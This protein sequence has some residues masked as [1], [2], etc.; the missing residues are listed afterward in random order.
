MA[1]K[2]EKK[3]AKQEKKAA[4]ERKR[5]LNQ[6]AP[7]EE[8]IWRKVESLLGTTRQNDYDRAVER[9]KDLRDLA[10]MSSTSSQW[11]KRVVE[12]RRQYSRKSALMR[13]F[14]AADFPSEETGEE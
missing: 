8:D 13:R 12:F 11:Q 4:Q 7:K 6:I 9:L 3:P 14:D 2:G 1:E 5:Y 10:A